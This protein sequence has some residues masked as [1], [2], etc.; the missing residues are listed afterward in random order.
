[1]SIFREIRNE[2]LIRELCRE[3]N[4]DVLLFGFDQFTYFGN[5]QAIEDGRIAILTPAIEART[6]NVEIAGPSGEVEETAFTRVDLWQV[7][8]KGTG[9][10]NDPL[11][12]YAPLN[13]AAPVVE[14]NTREE[15]RVPSSDLICELRRMI[16]D[17]VVLTTLGGFLF[18]GVLADIVDT[19]AILTVDEILIPGTDSS[20][21]SSD[22]RSVV[23]NLCALTSV[24][25]TAKSDCKCSP[26]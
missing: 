22:V 23:V 16:G 18:E 2:C 5:L 10:A 7:V 8:A 12:E 3:L 21:S 24:S 20:I 13:A 19:L 6:S 11:L 15:E 25:R 26:R 4:T 17:E 9:I 14:V 1:M